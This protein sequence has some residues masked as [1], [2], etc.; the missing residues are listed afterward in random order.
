MTDAD[1]FTP[2]RGRQVQQPQLG[3]FIKTQATA[4]PAK[5]D[6]RFRPLTLSDREEIAAESSSALCAK[7][8]I[9]VTGCPRSVVAPEPEV[10][11]SSKDPVVST[12][13]PAD[14][15]MMGSADFIDT[16][17]PF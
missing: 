12:M 2:V 7:G 17:F 6:S 8:E 9:A 4:Q 5:V 3:D 1:G 16:Q 13:G 11:G 10:G 15:S 14:L